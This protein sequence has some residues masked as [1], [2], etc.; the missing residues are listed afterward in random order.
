MMVF[1]VCPLF[2]FVLLVLHDGV[3]R[4]ATAFLLCVLTWFV[5]M[6][7]CFVLLFAVMTT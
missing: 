4:A 6:E 7:L 2:I 5:G 1:W 3:D